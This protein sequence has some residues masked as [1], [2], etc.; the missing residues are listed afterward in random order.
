MYYRSVLSQQQPFSSYL[1]N[2]SFWVFGLAFYQV[3]E[4]ALCASCVGSQV[5]SS[6]SWE[7]EDGQMETFVVPHHY[8]KF[9]KQLPAEHS[10]MPDFL[11]LAILRGLA[12]QQFCPLFTFGDIFPIP[13]NLQ[14]QICGICWSCF[15]DLHYFESQSLTT[16]RRRVEHCSVLSAMTKDSLPPI[17]P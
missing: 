4:D 17:L 1:S 11:F 12:E 6:G 15:F 3:G 8:Q 2:F 9:L 7:C 14:N 16:K 5:F 10:S 13:S